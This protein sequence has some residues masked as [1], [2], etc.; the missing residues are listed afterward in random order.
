[1][2]HLAFKTNVMTLAGS[3]PESVLRTS[4]RIGSAL[5]LMTTPA[6]FRDGPETG[7]WFAL[8]QPIRPRITTNSLHETTRSANWNVTLRT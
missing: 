1:M 8:K 5:V 2:P 4:R 7:R 6:T 3:A